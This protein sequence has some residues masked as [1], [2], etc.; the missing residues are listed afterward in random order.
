MALLVI[1][2]I[3]LKMAKKKRNDGI[4]EIVMGTAMLLFSPLIPNGFGP[5]HVKDATTIAV[6]IALMGVLMLITGIL[7][8]V[9]GTKALAEARRASTTT[10]QVHA[11]VTSASAPPKQDPLSILKERLARGEIT[12][13]EFVRKKALL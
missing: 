4:F 6:I 7:G 3:E 13:E 2:S 1:M 8:V 11:E 10:T 9:K 12:E 5:S